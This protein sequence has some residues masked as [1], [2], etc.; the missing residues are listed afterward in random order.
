MIQ[1]GMKMNLFAHT[2][3]VLLSLGLISCGGS[4]KTASDASQPETEDQADL[5]VAVV[6]RDSVVAAA[7]A[8]AAD[9]D[10]IVI[11]GLSWSMP[12][13]MPFDD[14]IVRDTLDNG[15]VLYVA[16]NGKPEARAELRLVVDAGSVLEDED[17]LGLAHFV[18]HMAFNGTENFAK[19]EIVNYLE[20][21]GMRFGADLN[22]YTSFDETVY[23]LQVPTDSI[24]VLHT[25]FQILREW[26]SRV[27]FEE[28]EIDKER[29]VVTEEWRLGRGANARMLDVQLPI[30]LHGSRYA[31]RL[32]IGDPDIIASAD[33]DTI[34]RF[35]R[36]WYRPDLMAV[37]AVGDFDVEEVA[38]YVRETFSD[39]EPSKEP[40]TRNTFDVPSHDSALVAPA[41][42]P[43]AP[44]ATVS[45]V[46][47]RDR[48]PE[49]AVEDYRRS[50]VG[51]LY[52]GMFNSR[53]GELTQVTD[54]PFAFASSGPGSFVRN[55]EFYTLQA[56]VR[57]GGS[58]RALETLLLEA[59]RVKKHGFLDSEL[60]RQK[61]SMLRYF[62]RAYI[63]RDKSESARYA[64]EYAR[65]FLESES[66]PGIEFEYKLVKEI[67]PGITL[68]EVNALADRLITEDSRVVLL[69]APETPEY[70]LPDEATVLAAFERVV[71]LEPE[72]YVDRTLDEPLIPV[73][74]AGGTV[75]EEYNDDSLGV[76]W[77]TLSNGVRVL[78]KPTDFKNDQILMSAASDGGTSLYPDSL[79]IP[80]VTAA[81]LI[82]Q[83]GLGAFGPI[84]LEKAL[85]GIVASVSPRISQLS[86]GLSGSAAPKDLETM[87]QLVYLY[88]TAARA[89]QVA[90][91]S[92]RVR[93][94]EI[95]ASSRL[96]PERAFS[97][98]ISVTMAQGHFRARPFTEEVLDE[99]DLAA[100]L[101]IFRERFEDAG[102]FTFYLVGNFTVDEIRPMVQQYLGGLPT[103]GR[104]ETWRDVGI[105]PPQG[106]VTRTVV[107]GI[108][109]KSRVRLIFTGDFEWD[110]ENRQTLQA[111]TEVMRLKLREVLREDLGG[112]YGVSVSA[113]TSRDPV[114]GYRFNIS[115]GCDPERVDELTERVMV[116]VDS[117]Q[118]FGIDDS[119][120]DK[121]REIDRRS[122]EERLKENGFWLRSLQFVDRYGQD[123]MTI[124]GGSASFLEKLRSAD[125]SEAAQRYL[126][127]S[128]YAKFVLLPELQEPSGSAES[129]QN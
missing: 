100:S 78:L 5:A 82:S 18:E 20:R 80:A 26:A 110:R 47:K 9:E 115:W 85:N 7:S 96:T 28:E 74:P 11:D 81:N 76:A 4:A 124:L 106:V 86:E 107:R 129:P 61:E 103:S 90:Y 54:P 75:V 55:A 87:F 72:P 114:E 1:A 14:S 92:Y 117:L 24:D 12:D 43:E 22:A 84:E 68:G 35:Y 52:H 59:E 69:D 91:D 45:V 48:E 128:N 38:D 122:H 119:Y 30:L 41:T 17:Q 27:S 83:S 34:R 49:G 37:I 127:Q 89:D 8:T 70:S 112:T 25:G 64:A 50:I 98:T 104:D 94:Q 71:L 108:E 93:V 77:M 116:Q 120:L 111:L 57:E 6:A 60:A 40:R 39:L 36:D 21:H 44:Y 42:D 56:L 62:E 10:T 2:H 102:D 99:M 29:G 53:L 13:P 31:E 63:E 58:E 88:F 97:D 23:I 65:N 19:H 66:V 113:S 123:P 95:M 126:D 118:S 32:P 51:G 121:I 79:Y 3:V 101:E 16:H 33:Y 73:L 46:H 15:L 109:P 105:R 125:I 67:L